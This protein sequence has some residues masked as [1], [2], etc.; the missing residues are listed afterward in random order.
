MN[1]TFGQRF[2]RL[3]KNKGFTQEDVATRIN[4]TAQA[5]SKW[6]NEGSLR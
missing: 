2:S 3:R 5:V 1:E 6:E 4:I